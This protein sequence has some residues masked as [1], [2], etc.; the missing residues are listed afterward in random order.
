VLFLAR[1]PVPEGKPSQ[2]AEGAVA[3]RR[4][5]CCRREEEGQGQ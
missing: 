5:G 1:C 3:A 4:E 2:E